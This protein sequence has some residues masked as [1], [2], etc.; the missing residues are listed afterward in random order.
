MRTRENILGEMLVKI[1]LSNVLA[2]VVDSLIKDAV[3]LAPTAGKHFKHK[4]KAE[5]TSMVEAAKTLRL[6]AIDVAKS[7]YGSDYTDDFCDDAT[8]IEEVLLELIQHTGGDPDKEKQVLTYIK[9]L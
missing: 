8:Y 4:K 5:Y 2:D 3:R 7:S 1:S 6:R 9:S